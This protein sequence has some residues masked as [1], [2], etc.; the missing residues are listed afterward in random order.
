MNVSLRFIL[1]KNALFINI[2]INSIFHNHKFSKNEKDSITICYAID[3]DKFNHR[4]KCLC[5]C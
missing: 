2:I 1:K 3:D 4:S 5:Q